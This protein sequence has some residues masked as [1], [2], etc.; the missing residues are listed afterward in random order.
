MKNESAR[1]ELA[2]DS[3]EM[4]PRPAMPCR[5]GIDNERR[6]ICAAYDLWD[7]LRGVSEMPNVADIDLSRFPT[8]APHVY[9]VRLAQDLG[10]SRIIHSGPMFDR[11]F[12]MASTG[13][14]LAE[15]WPRTY[16]DHLISYITS[17][18]IYRK[19]LAESGTL[20]VREGVELMHRNI[21]MP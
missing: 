20:I 21:L 8:I 18:K 12:D 14:T 6:V 19:P 11:A 15:V 3:P 13:L 1:R 2:G 16:R 7:Q 4:L 10:H 17:V 9:I 5:P